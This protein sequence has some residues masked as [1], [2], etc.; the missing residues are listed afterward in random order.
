M[1]NVNEMTIFMPVLAMMLL[2][3]L[4]WAT[5]LYR[6]LS[7]AMSNGIAADRLN[8]PEKV[9]ELL[10]EKA[11]APAYNLANLF[12]LPVLFYVLAVYLHLSNLVD[13]V[14]VYG[15]W[16]FFAFRLLHSVVHCSYNKVMHRF[17][18]YLL[19]SALLWFMLLRAVFLSV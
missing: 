16:G 5:L 17:A 1:A 19:S 13:A 4:V 8:T 14:F 11:M 9:K 15:A 6:R 3:M 10:P 18:A 7:N 12:E 2:T